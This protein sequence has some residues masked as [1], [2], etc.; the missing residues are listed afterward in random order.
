MN[1]SDRI[2]E[3]IDGVMPMQYEL[4]YIQ[5]WLDMSPRP[6]HEYWMET[7]SRMYEDYKRNIIAL[8]NYLEEEE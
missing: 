4:A 2:R 7:F 1:E 8:C 3:L 6:L 5:E